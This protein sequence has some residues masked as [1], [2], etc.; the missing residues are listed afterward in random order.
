MSPHPK[1]RLLPAL[2]LG[3][4]LAGLACSGESH[5]RREAPRQAKDPVRQ[6]ARQEAKFREA[7]VLRDAYLLLA[8][9]NADY[10]GHRVKAMHHVRQAV[11]ILDHSVLN[12][13][14]DAQKAA[15]LIEDS[16]AARAR[17]IARY[18]KGV[19]GVKEPQAQSDAQLR[20][21]GQLLAQVRA[22]LHRN[23]RKKP[24][25][26]VKQ[27]IAETNRALRVR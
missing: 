15:T 26:H 14:T 10:A 22:V 5:A 19:K 21:A 16:A 8:G 7:E 27:A 24:L 13:G 23:Q 18:V 2:S 17:V 11:K 25:G 4:L 20:A 6:A 9:A 1:D 3:A 12:K